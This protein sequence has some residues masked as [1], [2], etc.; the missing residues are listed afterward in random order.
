MAI[1][2]AL[3]H[4]SSYRYDRA[5]NLGPQIIR[6]RPAAHCRTRILAYH[7]EVKPGQHFLHWQQDPSGNFLARVT[8]PERTRE[9][10][11]KVS[12]LADLAAINPFDFFVEPEAEFFPFSYSEAE[13]NEL[14]PY[15][16]LETPPP[17]LL[18]FLKPF[19]SMNEQRSV[20]FLVQVNQALA[21]QIHYVVR[22]E[23]GVQ[24]VAETFALGSGSCRD[25]AWT[26]VQALRQLGLAARFVSGYLIQLR[27][28]TA[29]EGPLQDFCDLHAWTEVYL[30]G[31]G[32]IGLDSTSGMLAAE[33]HIPLACSAAPLLAAPI[34]GFSEPCDSQFQFEM[35]VERIDEG[36][37]SSR[38]YSE[39]QWRQIENVAAQVELRLAKAELGLTMGGEPTFVSMED[40]DAPEWNLA[41]DGGEKRAI[42]SRLLFR[43]RENLAPGAVAIHGQGKW[44]PGEPLPRW[45]I[46]ACWRADGRA[47]W[48]N[49]DLLMRAGESANAEWSQ[50]QKLA[51]ALADGAGVSRAALRPAL[52]DIYYQRWQSGE[53][54]RRSFQAMLPALAATPAQQTPRGLIL[55][56]RWHSTRQCWLSCIWPAPEEGLY[57]TPGDSPIGYRL[58]LNRLP[59]ETGPEDLAPHLHDPGAEAPALPDAVLRVQ[60]RALGAAPPL[61]PAWM[62]HT[63]A[64][65]ELRD[66]ALHIF[67]PPTLEAEAYVDLM[68]VVERALS[69]LKLRAFLE[70]YEAPP[71]RRLQRM[72]VT[73]DPGVLEVNVPPAKNWNE[74]QGSVETLYAAAAIE[75]L[76]SEKFLLD[77]RPTGTGGGA[78]ITLGGATPAESPFLARPALLPAMLCYWQR[79]PSL[80]Y[81]FSGLFVG[82]TS[83]APR[84]DEA[85]HESLYELEIALEQLSQKSDQAAAPWLLDRLLRNLLTDITGNTHRAEFCID[86]LFPPD[87][88]QQR[89]GLVELR[90]FEMPPHPQMYLAQ[91]LLVRALTAML[92]SA[93]PPRRLRRWGVELFDR[94]MLPHFL[95]EDFHIVLG[96]LREA[97][98]AL[99]EEHF[100]PFFEFRFPLYGETEIEGVQLQLRM[101]LEPW[102]VLGEISWQGAVSRPVDSAVERL[103]LRARLLDPDRY[104]VLCNMRRLPLS[105]G[106]ASGEY[107]AGV[108]YKAWN[109]PNTMHPCVPAQSPLIFDLVDLRRGRSAGGCSYYV[110]HPGGRAYEALPVNAAEAES[111][112]QSRFTRL[113]HTPGKIEI[114]A[115]ERNPESPM[116]LDLRRQR[117]HGPS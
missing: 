27:P 28:D 41:A 83:Q 87:R 48:Q 55:P 117:D 39:A 13:R 44:Y 53:F 7:L 81:L 47:L 26:M 40:R 22:M 110:S 19:R 67:L 71:D 114:P 70:G 97:G 43:L 30:P 58:P 60:Q 99:Q 23:S 88:W 42:A 113:G 32:W 59:P 82:P 89:L 21:K 93:R 74:L 103:E 38:P 76:H 107:V 115:A 101:A 37:R 11:V 61:D 6:L 5:V 72:A 68:A 17:A 91:Q 78:H 64:A 4:L 96:D 66:G 98:F 80:S 75:K 16:E 104:A 116:T 102:P 52:E 108:R 29:G 100:E 105:P 9:F 20:D 12:L 54:Y 84:I 106:G 56:L 95:R 46:Q 14:G 94:F 25:S 10:Q 33:G 85:R 2:V 77:G 69:V 36:P 8:V 49:P 51:E 65:I 34:S 1:R 24:S 57:L 31:A 109:P 3:H 45:A 62:F 18:D 86:K 15:L 63:A 92:S 111:R 73:P 35:T 112:R 90:A 79:H 50:L